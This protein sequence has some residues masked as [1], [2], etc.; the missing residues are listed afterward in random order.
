M[1]FLLEF[2]PSPPSA[3]G[4][5][6]PRSER[7]GSVLNGTAAS[8]GKGKDSKKEAFIPENVYDAVKENKRFD[9]I[10]VSAWPDTAKVGLTPNVIAWLPGR[11]GRVPGFL[12]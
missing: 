11:R 12:P 10:R 8:K 6:T 7:D 9:M 2:T 4:T 5:S 1:F 3:S